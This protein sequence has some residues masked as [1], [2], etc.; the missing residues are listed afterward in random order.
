M[1]AAPIEES[2]QAYSRPRREGR[3]LPSS[4]YHIG[5]RSNNGRADFKL[6]NSFRRRYG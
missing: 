1:R 4:A 5:N 2:P 3:A 6:T